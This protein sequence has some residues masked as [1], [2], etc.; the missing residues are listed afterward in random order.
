M[1]TATKELF[2]CRPDAE[3]ASV[4]LSRI[5]EKGYHRCVFDISEIA[6]YGKG[7]PKK[8]RPKIPIGFEYKVSA[9][10]ELDP[11]K[12]QKPRTDAGCFVLIANL[13]GEEEMQT[14]PA[15]ELP[16]LYKDQDGIE[17]NF[18]FLKE[19]AI[20]NSIFLKKT[21]ANRGSWFYAF[22]CA[23]DPEIDGT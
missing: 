18:S 6:R 20:V 1:K 9:T 13:S 19:P 21:R 14:W 22:D 7:R 3:A 16:R 17:K 2:K 8:D 23:V 5:V 11:D 10:V 15:A 12:I 4:R